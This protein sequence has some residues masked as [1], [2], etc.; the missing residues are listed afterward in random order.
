M[1]RENL[2]TEV[3]IESVIVGSSVKNSVV[4]STVGRSHTYPFFSDNP[5]SLVEQE[6]ELVGTKHL[7]GTEFDGL[8]K[9]GVY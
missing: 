6:A 7:S 1:T 4:F 8:E 3:P 2:V 9:F 5:F